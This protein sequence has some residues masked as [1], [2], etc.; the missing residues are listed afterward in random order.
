[1][2]GLVAGTGREYIA[3]LAWAVAT[4][5]ASQILAVLGWCC[6]FPWSVPAIL[7]GASGAEVEPVSTG[8]V[9][10]VLVVA[11][12]GLAATIAW[13]KSADQTG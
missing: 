12:L 5:A 10:L 9:A 6:W 4:I 3:P 8:A 13:W 7:A 2:H 1:M 11:C